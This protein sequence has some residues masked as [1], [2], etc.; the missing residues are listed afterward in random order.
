MSPYQPH[1]KPIL[2]TAL[3]PMSNKSYFFFT[4]QPAI[5]PDYFSLHTAA[6]Y[7][8]NAN[9]ISWTIQTNQLE[10]QEARMFPVLYRHLSETIIR[11]VAKTPGARAKTVQ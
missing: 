5:F 11:Q 4:F 9:Q 2:K 10:G 6:I 7:L 8:P 3:F 1:V